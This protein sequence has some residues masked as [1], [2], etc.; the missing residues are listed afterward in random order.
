MDLLMR[1]Y[2]VGE[3]LRGASAR[4][5][6]RLKSPVTSLV[7]TLTGPLILIAI[8]YPGLQNPAVFYFGVSLMI[9]SGSLIVAAK[10]ADRV[11]RRL[12]TIAGGLAAMYIAFGNFTGYHG[13]LSYSKTIA[14]IC[15]AIG[16]IFLILGAATLLSM[17]I[18]RLEKV[19]RL[20]KGEIS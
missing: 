14:Y 2:G 8:G 1:M 5:W 10:V 12:K 3:K 15:L 20:K 16:M 18:K 17:K 6:N 7:L 9:A 11:R 13:N 19:L 4:A